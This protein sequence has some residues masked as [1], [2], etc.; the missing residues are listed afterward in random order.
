MSD[1][2]HG[3]EDWKGDQ[4][5]VTQRIFR[6]TGCPSCL[7][8]ERDALKAAI[9]RIDTACNDNHWVL[10]YKLRAAIKAAVELAEGKE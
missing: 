5:Y 8:E 4:P 7:A 9:T 10:T 3:F 2:L 6:K 1:C